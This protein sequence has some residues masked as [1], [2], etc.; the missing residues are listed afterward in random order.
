MSLSIATPK[1]KR[2]KEKEDFKKERDRLRAEF[3]KDK[4][5][6]MANA[7]KLKTK[8]GADGYNP[9]VVQ[10]NVDDDQEADGAVQKK[11]KHQVSADKIDEYVTKISS[12]RAGGDGG[13]CLKI[14]HVI[15]GN[16]VDNPNEEKMKQINMDGKAYKT[17]IKPFVGGKQLLLALGFQ[18]SESGQHLVL[19]DDAD[20]QLLSDTRTKLKA[21]LDKY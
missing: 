13:R 16:V 15:V 12:Y 5:E 8:L 11:A 21:A 20:T 4:A 7:G 18:P 17:K 3:A 9:N 6:R 1:Q 14:L 10:Y 19:A 2:R